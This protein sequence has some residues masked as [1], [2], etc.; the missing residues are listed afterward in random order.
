MRGAS[1]ILFVGM[2]LCLVLLVGSAGGC[3]WFGGRSHDDAPVGGVEGSPDVGSPS[4]TD[5]SS[6]WATSSSS[7]DRSQPGSS[8]KGRKDGQ[9]EGQQAARANLPELQPIEPFIKRAIGWLVEA[10]HENGA[11]GAGSHANQQLRDPTKVKTDPAT[12]AFSAMALLRAGHTPTSGAYRDAVRRATEYL[13]RI[14][15]E[16]PEDGGRI[17]DI[18]GTQPQAKMGQLVDTSLA[19][20]FFSKVLPTLPASSPLRKRVDAALDKGLR[21]LQGSQMKDGSWG[22]SGGWAPV[23]QSSLGCTA[24]E[25]AQAI[26][27]EVNGE[28]LDLARKYQKGNFDTSTGR[29]SAD[30]AAGVELYAFAGSQRAS[31]PEAAAAKTLLDKAKAEGKLPED[32]EV[33][34]RSL[35]IAGLGAKRAAVLSNAYEQNQSQIARLSDESLIAG[36]GNNGGE[37]YLS[38]LMTSESLVIVGGEA[39]TKW[40][41]RMYERLQK[42]Q[43]PNGSWTGHH[44]ITSPVFCTAAV[45]QCLTA[46]RDVDLLSQIAKA[47]CGDD[48]EE[49]DSKKK[50]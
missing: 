22:K 34:A 37:E 31:A 47:A 23:L 39:W 33:S 6:G 26:G 21:K 8:D 1:G 41:D 43:S 30:A 27:K 20:Q 32:A 4:G 3:A 42:I 17:T 40:N 18:T 46:D 9:G 38:Y 2:V 25:L 13:V 45:I 15:E 16:S 44:C 48:L 12:T 5:S 24:L 19:V 28:L 50:S 11:W 29:A 7:A 14:V 10:Q 49:E 36:F 35:T